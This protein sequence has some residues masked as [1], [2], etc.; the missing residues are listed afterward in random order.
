M[1]QSE[2]RSSQLSS[3]QLG[4]L[5]SEQQQDSSRNGIPAKSMPA[6]SGEPASFTSGNSATELCL[7][8]KFPLSESNCIVKCSSCNVSAHLYCL[9]RRFRTKA[10]EGLKNKLEWLAEFIKMF[11]F[12]YCCPKCS[13]NDVYNSSKMAPSTP[14]ALSALGTRAEELSCQLTRMGDQLTAIQ[15]SLHLG[16]NLSSGVTSS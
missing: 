1:P 8:C 11:N 7:L 4:S 9:T 3:T 16:G 14:S 10:E 12:R 5:S 2:R 15:A 13:I 6:K